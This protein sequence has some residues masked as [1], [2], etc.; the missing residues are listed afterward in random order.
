MLN[1]TLQHPISLSLR[2]R[3]L[4]KLSHS[5]LLTASRHKLPAFAVFLTLFIGSLKKKI[6]TSKKFKRYKKIW[7]TGAG[8]QLRATKSLEKIK[9]NK[10]KSAKIWSYGASH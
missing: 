8:K 1:E 2:K 3:N 4:K 5:G 9:K 7:N 6:A 10:K